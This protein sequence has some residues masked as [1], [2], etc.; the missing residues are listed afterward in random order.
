MFGTLAESNFMSQQN[1]RQN[2]DGEDDKNK[3]PPIMRS[4]QWPIKNG[5]RFR[6][7][8]SLTE[9]KPA[10]QDSVYACTVDTAIE[11]GSSWDWSTM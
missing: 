8:L 10:H 3:T 9:T 7:L 1:V 5:P 4:C 2:V 6:D 11:T